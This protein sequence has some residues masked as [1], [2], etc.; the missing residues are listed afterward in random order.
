[1]IFKNTQRQ[2]YPSIALAWLWMALTLGLMTASSAVTADPGMQND[3]EWFYTYRPADSIQAVAKRMLNPKH[4]WSDLARHNRID[5]AKNVQAGSIIKIPM[6]WLKVQP[7]PAKVLSV[8]GNVLHKKARLS[9]YKML[10]ANQNIQVGDEVKSRNGTALIKLADTSII[11]LESDSHIHF[12]RL[13]HFGDTGMTDTKIRLKRGG[14]INTV[15]PLK[16]GSRYEVS[17]PSAVAAV[18]GTEFRMRTEGNR[19]KIEVTEGKVEFGN[20]QHSSIINTGE[21]AEV[22]TP[23]AQIATRQLFPA[24]Q[25]QTTQDSLSDLPT[26][27]TWAPVPGAEG[28]KYELS[29]M[30]QGEQLQAGEMSNPELELAN[31]KSGRYLLAMRAI[32]AEGFEGLNDLT[33]L[34]IALEGQAPM[35]LQP[36]DAIVANSAA[37]QFSWKVSNPSDLSKVQVSKDPEFIDLIVDAPFGNNKTF[38]PSPA[39]KPGEYFWRVVA[40]N[41]NQIESTSE[42][43]SIRLQGLMD[44]VQI[45]SVNYVNNQ[46]GLFWNTVD[47]ARG[48]VL[49]VSDHPEFRR[50]LREE[51]IKK[52]SAFLKLQAD[53]TYYAR[54][55]GIGNALYQSE[56]GPGKKLELEKTSDTEN[57]LETN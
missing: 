6:S 4:S 46:V 38:S 25:K 22:S 54:V 29:E 27:F 48:Y 11:R 12:N 17:S 24:P 40:L 16:R 3:S 10:K 55:K 52:S 31:L 57:K 8:N 50:I 1:M 13:S 45:L 23:S 33:Q 47:Q 36:L 9:T 35:P 15:A 44:E 39:L 49:Q 14:V 18:R 37:V 30:D 42:Q 5:N 41:Q 53:K 2:T 21:A 28:Y 26:Q 7:K 32:D 51:S 20:R 19:T 43:R 56:F 34:E